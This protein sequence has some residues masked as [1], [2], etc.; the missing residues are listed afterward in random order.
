VRD[1]S[2]IITSLDEAG[3]VK[4]CVDSLRRAIDPLDA[5]IVVAAIGSSDPGLDDV[6]AMDGRVRVVR[7]LN[8]GYAHANNEA[9]RTVDARYVL[10]LNPDTEFVSGSLERLV[11]DLD[12]R[13]G[14]GVVGARQLTSDGTVYPT[15]RRR[16]T[17]LR[18]LGE[19]LGS[20]R[21][22]PRVPWL[23]HRQLDLSSYEHEQVCDWTIGSFMLVRREALMSAG[24]MDER[25][26]FGVEEEDLCLRVRQAGWQVIH[27]PTVTIVHHV[28]KRPPSDRFVRQQ[29]YAKLQYA[30]KNF[31]PPRRGPY[32]LAALLFFGL[33]A[34]IGRDPSRRAHHG[35][36]VRVLLG[37]DRPPFGEP[38]P[39]A[40]PPHAAAGR[41][42]ELDPN[43]DADT[44][45][46]A[47]VDR[48]GRPHAGLAVE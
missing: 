6:V 27:T 24:Y 3:W 7:C 2:I 14:I 13:T 19:A 29:A 22:A 32:L 9:L 41:R 43:V 35:G 1:L 16:A 21:F 8:R 28:N 10:F 26:F 20:E 31:D 23:C 33:R 47:S 46:R 38:P 39:T 12:R 34:V 48:S 44:G 4:A 36:A 42:T 25:F 17:A 11:A 18:Q 45:V 30:R 15:I 5:E 37:L 40:L